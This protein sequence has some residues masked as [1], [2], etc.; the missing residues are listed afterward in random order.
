MRRSLAIAAVLV[1]LSGTLGCG[2]H[3][4]GPETEALVTAIGNTTRT[5]LSDDAAAEAG[6]PAALS[7]LVH[8]AA[9]IAADGR[10]PEAVRTDLAAASAAARDRGWL[11]DACLSALRS[12]YSRMSG[13]AE[14]SFPPDVG[15]IESVKERA[16]GQIDH[17]VA[18]LRAG[19]HEE[20]T[21]ALVTFL[22]MVATPVEQSETGAGSP[23]TSGST[24]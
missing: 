9:R 23:T 24:R 13:G 10:L 18:A 16:R 1:V 12:A 22:L 4:P 11:D 6:R 8:T 3:A 7:A 2:S 21:R 14:F 19:R 17:C 5:L 20:A 15:G